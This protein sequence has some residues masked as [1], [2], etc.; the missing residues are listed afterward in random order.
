MHRAWRELACISVAFVVVGSAKLVAACASCGCGDPTI[1]SSGVERPYKNRLRLT[2]DE[3]Y[4]S[5]SLGEGADRE[6]VQF[7]RSTLAVSWSPTKWLTV[8]AKLPWLTSFIG[9]GT[10]PYALVNGLGDLELAGRAVL[11]RERGFAPHH[12]L[13]ASLGLKLPTGYAVH[14]S[15]GALVSDDDQPGSGSWDPFAGITYAWHSGDLLSV[16]ASTSYRYTTGGWHGYRR[17]MSIGASAMLQVQPKPWG[18]VQVGF[19]GA[20]QAADRFSDGGVARDTGGTAV[21]AAIGLVGRI[22]SD[23]LIRALVDVPAV[24]ALNGHQTV[25]PQ[26]G[27]SVSYDIR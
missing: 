7:L 15:T 13:S 27:V 26:V 12:L 10:A 9:Y 22:H 25:G 14:D 8:D 1:T 2:V 5:L 3:R 21:Y 17:G 24:L 11:F 6:R 4:G 19:D 20:W 18:A 16:F 23:L